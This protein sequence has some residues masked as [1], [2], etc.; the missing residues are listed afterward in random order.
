MSRMTLSDRIQIEAGIYAQKSLFTRFS[1]IVAIIATPF[2]R[3]CYDFAVG[4]KR[5]V[6]L[7]VHPFVH[8]LEFLTNKNPEKAQKIPET[9][10]FQ[11]FSMVNDTGLVPARPTHC[12]RSHRLTEFSD[13]Q[14]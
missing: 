13:T 9:V 10:R 12:K 6:H 4:F 11:G 2:L 14:I 8:L 7:L 5:F 1:L 3:L